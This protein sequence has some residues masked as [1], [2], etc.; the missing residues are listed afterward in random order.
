[1]TGRDFLALAGALV[2]NHGHGNAESRFRTAVSRAYY[3][4]FHVAV[5]FLAAFGIRVSGGPQGHFDVFRSSSA[6]AILMQSRQL[7]CY[8]TCAVTATRPITGSTDA[9]LAFK[10]TP[11]CAL[12][13]RPTLSPRSRSV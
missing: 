3:A 5:E 1:M 6:P 8:R 12:R 10:P 13:K 4:S 11:R 2:A 9:A 7:A